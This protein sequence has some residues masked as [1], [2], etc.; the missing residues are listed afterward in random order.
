V[1]VVVILSSKSIVA[2]E[3]PLCGVGLRNQDSGAIERKRIQVS[4]QSASYCGI[5]Q[6]ARVI[7]VIYVESWIR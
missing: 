5:R 7:R 3:V 1:E 6:T 2:R 4:N